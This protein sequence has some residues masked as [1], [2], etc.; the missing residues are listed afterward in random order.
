MRHSAPKL[1]VAQ[2]F[3]LGLGPL[4]SAMPGEPADRGQGRSILE[5]GG[6]ESA[7][8]VSAGADGLV[9]GWKLAK[10]PQVPTAWS[11]NTAYPGALKVCSSEPDSPAHGGKRFIRLAAIKSG[12]AHLYQMCTGLQPGKWYRVSAW[13]RGGAVALSFYEY[14][15]SGKMGGQETAQTTAAGKEWK[16]IQGFYCPPNGDYVRSALAISVPPGQRADVDDVAI[17]PIELPEVPAGAADITLETDVLRVA[18][19]PR[20]RLKEFR[21][22]PS[23]K[24]YAA[25]VNPLPMMSLTRGGVTT[26][27]YSLAREGDLLKAQ[28]LDTEVRA[29]LRVTARNRHLLFEVVDVQP[30]DAEE[31]TLEFPVKRLKSV[32]G[33]FNATYDD[34]FGACLLGTTANVWQQAAWRGPE[35][36]ALGVRCVRKHGIVGARF[37][38]VAAPWDQ[39]KPAIMEAERANGLP[40]PMLEGQWARD[41][42]AV[43]RSYL[44]V[45]DATEKS[46]DKTIEYAKL[47]H[48]GMVIFL[49]ENWLATHGHFQVNTQNFP[50][51]RASLKRAVAKIHAAGMGAGVHVF[52][53]S[54]SP[55]DPYVTPKPDTRLASVPCP[56][57]AEA[58]DE[59]SPTLTLAGVPNLPPI[60]P[61]SVAFPGRC[62]RVGDE[63]IGYEDVEPGPPV[64]IVRCHRGALGTKAARHPAGAEVKG[65]LSLWG[66]FLVDPDSTLA[67]DLTSNFA[68]VFN[69][70]DFDMVYFDASDGI[71]GPYMDVWYYLNKLHLGY[72]RK[73][74]KDVLYQTSMG[75][76][77]DLVWHVV[78]RSA[79]ADG[80]GDLKRYLDERLPG[81]LGMEANFTRPDVGWYYMYTDVRPDQIEY[82]CAKTI[83]LD[84]SISIETSREAMESHPRARQ[85]IEMAGQ[86]EAC[87]LAKFFPAGVQAQLRE[88]GKDFKL[89]RDGAGWKLYRA[90]Y[91][92]PRFVEALDGKQNVWTIRNER[93]E[94]SPLGVEIACGARNVPTA[95]Y[96]QPG[97]QTIESFDDAAPYRQSD[98][99]RLERF[100]GGPAVTPGA[101]GMAR[102]GV[103][104]SF[105]TS[106][107][108]PQVGDRCA[109]LAAKNSGGYGGWC[110]VARRL[111]RP[112]DLSR[113]QAVGLWVD[114]DG[115][116][117]TLLVQLC[118]AA[119]RASNWPVPVSFK[120]WRLCVFRRS[121]TPAV[122]WSKADCLILRLQG[123]SSGM[124]VKVRFDDLRALPVLHPATPL[125]HPAVQVNGRTVRFPVELKS[126][127]A[128]TSEGPGGVRLWPGGMQPGQTVG[129]STEV[130]M[131]QPGENRII[132]SADA[133]GG[134]PG[135]ASLLMYRLGPL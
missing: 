95:D 88:P 118:D 110:G 37:A 125:S 124:S 49:K 55:N 94:P 6:V 134:Y 89:F 39:F 24:D 23:G 36:L 115:E 70:C 40:C 71:F 98:R 99:N 121:E 1:A 57:L 78:P 9:Q 54:I 4:H 96:H 22:K 31:L 52:G 123:L 113:A 107:E 72:Y 91:E 79:S 5:N 3:G 101:Q 43:R 44:F 34:Q 61:S 41:S 16:R 27:L 59:K 35:V 104:M 73:F 12:P 62:L 18:I 19:A 126:G 69:E 20:G 33:A 29:T 45:V 10:P 8:P 100:F 90:V 11:L 76:G 93:P 66:F 111:A 112:L 13:V 7:G 120:G 14:F 108:T 30:A 92:E 68:E 26:P 103:S 32:G 97:T 122:D 74:K 119:G 46:I 127:Q 130:L 82:V 116:G 65:L 15:K 77:T 87:R 28:F 50:E 51:G 56:P 102:E 63:L 83:G 114:G 17:E 80:H 38:L 42:A 106:A 132:F 2:V 129:V 67:D 48:F 25:G 53:P 84:S 105:T 81:M 21:S 47:G 60:A 109:V 85:M 117:E 135:D 131:L 75:T 86:Y 128:L 133:A 58:V 64:R